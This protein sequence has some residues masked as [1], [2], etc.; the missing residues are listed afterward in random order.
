MTKMGNTLDNNL[1]SR[2]AALDAMYA[3]CDTGETLKE[4]PWR[5]NPHIDA[6]V[7]TIEEL[8]SVNPQTKTKTGHWESTINGKPIC[9]ECGFISES[10]DGY[11]VSNYCPNCGANMQEVEDGSI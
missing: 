9:S 8:P 10:L 1:I 11:F 3:L 4:N 5:D 7:E 2:Q 6:V